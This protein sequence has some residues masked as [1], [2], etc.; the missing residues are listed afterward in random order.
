MKLCLKVEATSKGSSGLMF[1]TFKGTNQDHLLRIG[2]LKLDQTALNR[3][4][5]NPTPKPVRG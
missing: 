3:L 1:T 4:P 2:R 5:T